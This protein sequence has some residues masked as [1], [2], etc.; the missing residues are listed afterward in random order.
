MYR[1]NERHQRRRAARPTNPSA[2]IAARAKAG[3]ERVAVGMAVA[4]RVASDAAVAAWRVMFTV[5]GAVGVAALVTMV[6]SPASW[7]PGPPVPAGTGN[8]VAPVVIP[9]VTVVATIG[10]T[11][12]STGAVRG[13]VAFTVG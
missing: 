6:F 10:G 4:V 11:L 12:T 8:T 1:K 5:G 2:P 3:P 9:V 7:S 13:R